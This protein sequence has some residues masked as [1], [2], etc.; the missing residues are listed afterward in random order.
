MLNYG[1]LKQRRNVTASGSG[2]A[3]KLLK[4]L[5]VD[6]ERNWGGGEA[7]VLGLISYLASKG[8]RNDLLTHPEGR[9]FAAAANLKVGRYPMVVRNDMDLRTVPGIRRRIA[10]GKYD[11]VHLHTKRAHALSLW[12]SR[13]KG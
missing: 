3:G 4:I 9:L 10:D 2:D 1:S 8:H 12:L 6:P 7:Q 13:G 5:H 11:I